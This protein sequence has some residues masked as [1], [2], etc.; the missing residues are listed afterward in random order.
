MV[1]GWNKPTP[2]DLT[3]LAYVLVQQQRSHAPTAADLPRHCWHPLSPILSGTIILFEFVVGVNVLI[4]EDIIMEV[5]LI[6]RLDGQH[7]GLRD[8]VPTVAYE[9]TWLILAWQSRKFNCWILLWIYLWPITSVPSCPNHHGRSS[10]S[11]CL[12]KEGRYIL[13]AY[14]PDFGLSG[15]IRF[16]PYVLCWLQQKNL[17]GNK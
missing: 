3:R 10:P 15:I 11:C 1:I 17:L 4:L 16:V 6:R 13:S 2:P 8:T 12:W 7:K 5:I 9:S 14:Y